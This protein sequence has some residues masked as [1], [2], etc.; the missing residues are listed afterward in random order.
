MKTSGNT[1]LITGGSSGIGLELAT[2]LLALGNTVIITGRDQTKLDL[3]AKI[4]PGIHTIQ[5]DVSD[6]KAIIA[7][8]EVVVS[9]FPEL[10]ILINN[11]GIMCRIN[12]N[13]EKNDLEDMTREIDTNL[14]GPIRMVK[15]F[16][17]HLKTQENV[18]IINVSSALAFVPLP[19]SPIYCA[20]KAA[21]HSFTQSLR[22]Q[23][24]HTNIKVFELAPPA[25]NTSSVHNL[26]TTDE[27]KD[28]QLMD[29]TVLVKHVIDG[30]EKN[31]F[32]IRP[33]S[34]NLLNIMSRIAPGFILKQLSKPWDRA[35]ALE[36]KQRQKF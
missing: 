25:I 19:I 4:L 5:S 22:V 23:L 9:E 21:L 18:A 6:A 12:L 35:I 17:P 20:T 2:Q 28:M 7:L 34:S 15:Q 29:I 32:E 16:I 14:N 27:L 11:A 13:D 24:K 10:N 8:H 30:I 36:N 3:A 33:G 26:L 1:I 31:V